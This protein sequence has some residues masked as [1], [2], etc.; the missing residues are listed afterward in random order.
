MKKMMFVVLSVVFTNAEGMNLEPTQIEGVYRELQVLENEKIVR[1]KEI[2]PIDV[3]DFTVPLD[4]IP[5]TIYSLFNTQVYNCE[6]HEICCTRCVLD[7]SKFSFAEIVG[8]FIQILQ[9]KLSARTGRWSGK[10]QTKYKRLQCIEGSDDEDSIDPYYAKIRFQNECYNFS[11]NY[12]GSSR[13][14]QPGNCVV[15]QSRN[16]QYYR[17]EVPRAIGSERAKEW[18]KI[19]QG[20]SLEMLVLA[21]EV[22]RRKVHDGEK[23]DEYADLPIW[24]AIVMAQTLD[25]R[26]YEYGIFSGDK[27]KRSKGIQNIIIK[28]M[29]KHKLQN[30]MDV[31]ESVS[32]LIENGFPANSES[33]TDG[34]D[35]DMSGTLTLRLTDPYADQFDE[36]DENP[37]NPT[38]PGHHDH[39]FRSKS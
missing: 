35:T 39:L 10:Y 27:D 29:R 21:A 4:G 6:F 18:A 17:R 12:D 13:S 19:D 24:C 3:S 16:E 30:E 2:T 7:F 26:P 15:R 20:S 38:M 14:Y 5:L 36:Y 37:L 23:K 34:S 25:K 8:S 22:A 33:C 32:M 1:C 9:N 28:F 11:L 31:A